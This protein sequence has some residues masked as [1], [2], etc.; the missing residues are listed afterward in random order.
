MKKTIVVSIFILLIST[1]ILAAPSPSILGIKLGMKEDA[2]R[3]ILQKMGTQQK[4]E[5]KEEEEEGGEEEIWKLTKNPN[6]QSLIV[7]FDRK[8]LVRY[9]TVFAREKGSGVRYSDVGNTKEAKF[10]TTTGNYRYT[11]DVAAKGKIPHF[12][13]ILRGTNK[14]LL[15]SYSIKKF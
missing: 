14:D 7:G 11:W 10:E 4:E 13:V 3:R 9:V 15:S 12:I 6:Y 2:V 8:H 1:C 5:K